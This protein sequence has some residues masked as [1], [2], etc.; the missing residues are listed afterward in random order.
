MNVLWAEGLLACWRT[1]REKRVVRPSFPFAAALFIVAGGFALGA[2]HLF[3]HRGET[4][5]PPLSFACVQPDIPQIV[6]GGD[7]AT[8]SSGCRARWTRR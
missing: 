1:L 8:S 7:G 5:G 2:H 6:G 4:P 3:R